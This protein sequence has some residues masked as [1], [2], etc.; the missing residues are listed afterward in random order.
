MAAI[1]NSYILSLYFTFFLQQK[2]VSYL[3]ANISI[4]IILVL[5]STFG[6]DSC[7]LLV[8]DG[9][10]KTVDNLEKYVRIES[11]K[12]CKRCNI[13]EPNKMMPNYCSQKVMFVRNRIFE[14]GRYFAQWP[15]IFIYLYISFMS[16]L[17][18]ATL[19]LILQKTKNIHGL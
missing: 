2:F 16:I 17:E 5:N 10:Q 8:N 12:Y 1:L 6:F 19:S 11:W 4:K 18:I 13:V 3:H 14:K 7:Q 15:D 9:L